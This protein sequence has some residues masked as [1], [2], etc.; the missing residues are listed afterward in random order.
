MGDTKDHDKNLNYGCREND[1]YELC[2]PTGLSAGGEHR[3]CRWGAHCNHPNVRCSAASGAGRDRNGDRRIASVHT[4]RADVVVSLL[5]SGPQ[6]KAAAH[7]EGANDIC[8]LPKTRESGSV[9]DGQ[10]HC[11]RSGREETRTKLGQGGDESACWW[12][13]SFP[14]AILNVLSPLYSGTAREG[15]T[16]RR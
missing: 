15:A 9:S 3:V 10:G 14:V 5:I 13:R 8:R 4:L 2:T 16:V 1:A 6:T 7:K 11:T 12:K